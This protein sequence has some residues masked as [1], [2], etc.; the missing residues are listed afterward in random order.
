MSPASLGWLEASRL[1]PAKTGWIHD[2]CSQSRLAGDITP[3]GS[4][5]SRLAAGIKIQH[6]EQHV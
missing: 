1:Q 5:Q 6:R 4:S 2:A 3:P